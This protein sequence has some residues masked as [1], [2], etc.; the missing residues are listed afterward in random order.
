M[1]SATTLTFSR[2]RIRSEW[3]GITLYFQNPI[4]FLTDKFMNN[5][6]HFID[7]C[8]EVLP[9]QRGTTTAIVTS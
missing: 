8:G 5:N 9:T 1:E 2:P 7:T 4:N 3:H 6:Q